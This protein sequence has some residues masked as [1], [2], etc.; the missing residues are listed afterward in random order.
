M[1]LFPVQF[2][3]VAAAAETWSRYMRVGITSNRIHQ[4]TPTQAMMDAADE[5]GF[6]LKPES[7]IRGCPGYEP[8]VPGPVFPQSVTELVRWW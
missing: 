8:C 2:T 5:V 6:L 3:P 1:D 4:S 7:P